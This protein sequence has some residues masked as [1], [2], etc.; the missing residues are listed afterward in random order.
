MSTSSTTPEV[1]KGLATKVG[2]AGSVLLAVAS[3]LTP[4]LPDT[5]AG[6]SKVLIACSTALAAATVLGRM[7]QSAALLFGSKVSD[8]IPVGAR[9]V[10]DPIGDEASEGWLTD[11]SAES[12]D[13]GLDSP[14]DGTDVLDPSE[15]QP[16]RWTEDR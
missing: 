16:H 10:S 9:Q 11:P 7:L 12:D 6:T 14:G 8:P 1:P 4:F 3:A 13:P 15:G 5:G 2:L